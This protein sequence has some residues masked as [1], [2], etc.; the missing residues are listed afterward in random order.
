MFFDKFA[1][2]LINFISI[3]A[4]LGYYF[5]EKN[6]FKK[7]SPARKTHLL[8]GDPD[9]DSGADSVAAVGGNDRIGRFG[10][11]GCVPGNSV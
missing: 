9:T 2:Q 7:R 3:M 11:G 6:R 1:P 10:D 8:D 5:F 4:I